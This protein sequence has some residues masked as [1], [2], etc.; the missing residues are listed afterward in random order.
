MKANLNKVM[1]FNLD[2]T[3]K[4]RA[5]DRANKTFSTTEL[6]DQKI[7]KIEWVGEIAGE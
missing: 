1:Q 4:V 3:V 7:Y 6:R 5:W 2:E